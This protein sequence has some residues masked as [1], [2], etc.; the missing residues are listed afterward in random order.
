MHKLI[1]TAALSL[2]VAAPAQAITVVTPQARPQY[3]YDETSVVKSGDVITFTGTTTLHNTIGMGAV[4]GGVYT[5]GGGG[6]QTLTFLYELN[7]R[8]RDFDRKGD[9]DYTYNYSWQPVTNDPT[10]LAVADK[11]CI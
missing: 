8:N 7:C 3:F 9:A 5:Y 4:V 10:A 6:T 11:Y 1:S 2:I